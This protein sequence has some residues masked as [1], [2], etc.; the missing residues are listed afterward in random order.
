MRWIAKFNDEQGSRVDG[1]SYAE[2]SWQVGLS[3]WNFP[4]TSI[5]LIT[6]APMN[7][8]T[9]VDEVCM[10]TPTSV[11]IAPMNI[12]ARRPSLSDR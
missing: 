8:C 1:E 2:A 3:L 4:W 10:M 5:L 6:R 9:V 12:V 7:T 11:M